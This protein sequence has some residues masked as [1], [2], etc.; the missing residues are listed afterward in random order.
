MVL[1][2]QESLL[3][4]INVYEKVKIFETIESKNL[5]GHVDAPFGPK[6]FFS[7][8]NKISHKNC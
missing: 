7:Y 5:R 6:R 8:I 1:V 2:F 3:A 4:L